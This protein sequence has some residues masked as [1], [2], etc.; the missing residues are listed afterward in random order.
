MIDRV[1]IQ[2]DVVPAADGVCGVA[3]DGRRWLAPA[4]LVV[5]VARVRV[6]RSPRLEKTAE[7]SAGPR[8]SSRS[9]RDTNQDRKDQLAI[10]IK[11]H[12]ADIEQA[13]YPALHQNESSRAKCHEVIVWTG[14]GS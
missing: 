9:Q 10:F 3:T 1:G 5:S 6:A 11:S 4:H 2:R 8:L 7:K 13:A 12:A 14:C